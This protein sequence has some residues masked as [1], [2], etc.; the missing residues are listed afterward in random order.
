M[1]LL[2]AD[3]FFE[4]VK[5]NELERQLKRHTFSRW[6]N[7]FSTT[8]I[9]EVRAVWKICVL[10]ANDDPRWQIIHL[11]W[12][13]VN[14]FLKNITRSQEI[15]YSTLILRENWKQQCSHRQSAVWILIYGKIFCFLQKKKKNAYLPTQILNLK[16]G[17]PSN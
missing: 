2:T 16:K 7:F 11:F 14:S 3:P 12:V 15:E 4:G 9:K 6:L 10:G 13:I 1:V 17:E 5:K 8:N